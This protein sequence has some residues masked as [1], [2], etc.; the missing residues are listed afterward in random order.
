M[1]YKKKI[2]ILLCL[3][4]F[5]VPTIAQVTAQQKLEV[6]RNIIRRFS[7]RDDINLRL[8][9]RKQGQLETFNQQVSNGKLTISANSPIALCHG[10]YDW[11]RQNE[12]GIMSWTGNRCSIPTKIDGSKTRSVTSPFQYHYYFNAVTFGYTMPYWDWNRWEQEIDWMAFHG[13][14]MPLALTA[15][16]AILARVFKKIGLSDEVIGRFFTGPAHLPWLRM[17]NIYGID[18]PLSNQWHQDQIALQHKILDRMRKLDMHPICPGFAG[19]VPEALKELYP[20]AD[21]QYTT[22]EKAFHNYILSPA[23]PLFHKI[24]VMFIQE[25]EKEFGRCD[26]YLIDS[27]NEMDIPFPPK[28]DPKRYEFMADF[29]KK[30]YQCIKEANPSAT[31]VMQ[32]WMFG[33]QP[34]IWDYK[35]LNALVSQ[36]PDN[37]MIMLDLA[38]DYNKFLWKTPFNWDF[39]KGFCGKQWIYS[40]IPNMGGKSALTGAL[41]FYAKGHLEALNSQNRGK[42]IGFGFAPEGIENNEV[43]YEL[44]CDAGWAKQG[45]ELRP[46]LR[47][48]TYSRYGCYPIGMEQYWN[49]MLQSVYGSFKSHPRFNWQFRP[50]KEKYGSV[51]LDNHFYHAVE[52]MAGMLSQMNGNKLFEA[53]F[54]EMAANYLGGKVEILVRQIDKAY[55]SQDTINA[56]QLETRFYRLMTGM[57]LVLQGHPTKDMQKWIDYA[58]ARGVSYNK[59]DCYESNARRIVTVWGP[60]IDD[61]SARI[62]AGLIRDYYL[63]RWKHYF[64]QKR[65]GKPFDFSTWELDFV[66][67]QKGLS[68][69]AL[70]KDKIS[71]AVQLIQDA[72][73]IVE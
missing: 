58:R 46:W 1:K 28:D 56:N 37:K 44:L 22:W 73:N 60:P 41:D 61:Y 18:G 30:V 66:E 68:Q 11:I 59:A 24:G 69:P 42:L 57:D 29:G 45:V 55:E 48:Y 21:I 2:Y 17:G 32:G 7:H 67:N 4:F 31:W 51:D 26:F 36:V 27:F 40:V 16:E 63:P 5:S 33:Y 3:W 53:D 35:T 50:G 65:S 12:Y 10:Y 34:E 39:Y 54:K 14:D 62:W 19:F 71:L 6:V 72:K 49:E 64:N 70:T 23:D 38:V 47:N 13:I 8:I 43:V 20:T 52:I 9:P 25:W 15:N